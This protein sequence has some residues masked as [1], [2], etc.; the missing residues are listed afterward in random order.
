MSFDYTENTGEMSFAPSGPARRILQIP[1][2]VYT[3]ATFLVLSLATLLVVIVVP[4]LERRRAIARIASRS[5]LWL[6]GMPLSIR[7]QERIPAGQCVIVAN[8]CSYVDGFVLAAALPPR[9]GF[10][11]KRELANAP[12][13][14]LLLQ[15]IGAEFV[16]RFD[17]HKGA[18]DARRLLR[19]AANGH[20]LVFFPEGT[21]SQRLGLLRFHTG[22]FATAARAGVPVVPTLLRGTRMALPPR[23]L[24][25]PQRIV[26]EFLQA[27]TAVPSSPD[28]AASELRDRVR[29]A[30]LEG[31]GEPDLASPGSQPHLI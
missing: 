22:A 29:A 19:T 10:V 7:H 26:V 21:F 6:V 5:C 13:A 14:G 11:I 15:R 30:M 31:L 18:V 27:Q 28:L 23:R 9:F 4:G 17:R 8:H 24:P 1:Y 16:E 3:F 25:W 2:S 12:L 20:S